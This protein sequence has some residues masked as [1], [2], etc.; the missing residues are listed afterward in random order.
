MALGWGDVF[1]G[2]EYYFTIKLTRVDFQAT[3]CGRRNVGVWTAVCWV[4]DLGSL[5]QVVRVLVEDLITTY[6]FTIAIAMLIVSL[7]NLF[8][9][10]MS[11]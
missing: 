1:R 7:Y 10:K 8:R 2:E 3:V 9:Q 5:D 4:P 6:R 11:N